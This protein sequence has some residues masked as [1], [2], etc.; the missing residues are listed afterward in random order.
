MTQDQF[1]KLQSGDVVIDG[2]GHDMLIL[3]PMPLDEGKLVG[4]R[5]ICWERSLK[6]ASDV[7]LVHHAT[8]LTSALAQMF[9][10]DSRGGE[11]PLPRTITIA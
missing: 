4:W 8:P 1:E 6:H 9:R 7:H 3:G 5:A 2:T 11:P 10:S